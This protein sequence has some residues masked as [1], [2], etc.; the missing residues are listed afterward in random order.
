M[1]K[2]KL[3]THN[4]LDG[5][6]SNIMAL[7]YYL[8]YR[9]SVSTEICSYGNIDENIRGY[10]NSYEY[11]SNAII[12]ITD[13]SPSEEVAEELDKIP[14]K[15]ILLDHHKTAIETFA[16]EKGNMK[17]DWMYIKEGD[18]ASFLA[19]RYFRDLSKKCNFKDIIQRY[20]LY[21]ELV[22]IA[23]LWDSKPRESQGF[24]KNDKK[25]RSILN[26]FS[27]MG[28]MTFRDRFFHRPSLVFDIQEQA[29]DKTIEK[30]K[31][32]Y[33][34]NVRVYK[35]S[36]TYR[37]ERVFFGFGFVSEY[38]SEVAEYMVITDKDLLFTFTLD[39]NACSG[40]LRKNDTHKFGKDF[41]VSEIAEQFGGGGHPYAAG[42]EFKIEDYDKIIKS[43]ITSDFKI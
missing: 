32:R 20:D 37:G 36:H 33:I 11:D 10:L 15:K 17:Y 6:V 14:N 34:R 28:F 40:S 30:I 4:D 16:D 35:L 25:I 23:D 22:Y 43:V 3:F 26:L 39:L 21:K 42:F 27:G 38:I 31:N 24:K 1:S 7:I 18:S 12:V 5:A 2:V 29:I 8:S 41:D 13:I 9:Y 19:F